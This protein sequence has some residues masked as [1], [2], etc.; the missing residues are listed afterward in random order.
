M[1]LH[2]ATKLAVGESSVPGA[3]RGVFLTADVAEGEVLE[4]CHYVSLDET[5][6]VVIDKALQDRVFLL[7]PATNAYVMGFGMIYNTSPEPNVRWEID[8]T[9]KTFRF[10]AKSDSVEG[11]ELFLDYRQKPVP[12][13]SPQI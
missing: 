6:F 1:R 4:E 5:N 7:P 10:I 8:L 3:G 2:V 13:G 11:E 12:V 9:R